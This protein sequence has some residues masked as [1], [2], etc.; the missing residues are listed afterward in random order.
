MVPTIRPTC[1]ANA[2]TR[3]S[4]SLTGVSSSLFVIDAPCLCI[5]YFAVRCHDSEPSRILATELRRD[6]EF[7]SDD[8]ISI[9][10]DTLHDNRSGY[11]FRTNPLGTQYDALVTDEGRVT[12]PNWNERW[13]AASTMDDAG[14]MAEI[15][16]P[17]R[18]LRITG[19]TDQTW[20]ID[21]ERVI[22]RKSEFAYWS[23]Y[24]R[25]FDF[26]KVSQAGNLV[27]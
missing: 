25:A 11:L 14:W 10:L 24:R 9:L 27:A 23:N 8:S 22:R 4:I 18:A 3:C 16:I 7:V 26:A 15:E 5:F 2:I 6:N 19:E 20:G 13:Y 12:D 21:F 17:F 1:S